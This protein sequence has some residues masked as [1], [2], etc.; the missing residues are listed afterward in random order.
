MNFVCFIFF[1]HLPQ[2]LVILLDVYI[3]RMFPVS[4]IVENV[5]SAK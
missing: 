3:L 4:Y 5:V 2:F 1:K